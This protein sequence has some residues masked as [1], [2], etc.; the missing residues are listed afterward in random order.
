MIQRDTLFLG[1]TRPAMLFGVTYDL[2]ML[3]LIGAMLLIINQFFILKIV[4]IFLASHTM[5]YAICYYEPR[6]IDITQKYGKYF[7]TFRTVY[8]YLKHRTIIFKS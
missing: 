5:L 4:L 3:N 7:I 2:F 1:L 8:C 6:I